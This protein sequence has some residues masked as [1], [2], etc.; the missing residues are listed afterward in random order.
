MANNY[1]M[2]ACLAA[3]LALGLAA[4]SSNNDGDMTEVPPPPEPSGPTQE[5]LDAE[6]MRA[7]DAEQ[8]LSDAEQALSDAEQALSDAEQALSDAEQALSDKEATE[9]TGALT[10]TAGKLKAALGDTPLAYNVRPTTTTDVAPLTPAGLVLMTDPDQDGT[11]MTADVDTPRMA[12]G[13]SAGA[14]GDW[15]GTNYAHTNAAGVT[16][17]AI[18]YTNQAG[19]KTYPILAR[20]VTDGQAPWR[21]DVRS[22]CADADLGHRCRSE[23]QVGHV[24]GGR[25]DDLY[26][27]GSKQRGSDPRHL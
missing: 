22:G 11:D 10:E 12:T 7:D 27:G 2:N 15:A 9:A 25:T 19:V 5:D 16:N 1:L 8:A 23:H 4:C 24:P 6:T 3:V 14:L 26:P 18:V 13:D 21:R 20:Y 17:S